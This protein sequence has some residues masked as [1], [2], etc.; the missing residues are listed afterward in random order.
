MSLSKSKGGYEIVSS[1][2]STELFEGRVVYLTTDDKLYRYT[3]SAWT[4]AVDGLDLVANSV[5]TNAINTGAVTAAKID[6]TSL[7]A[8]TATIGTLRT[9]T[10]G[11]RTEIQDNL[12]EVY[13]ASNV[14]R[15]QI[16]VW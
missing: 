13:D 7:S 6:V 11:A 1:L 2:P 12:I 9:A 16:G 10:S 3:G 5:T 15:V 4:K 8:I 14:K